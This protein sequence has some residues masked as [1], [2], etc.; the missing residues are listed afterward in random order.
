M[1]WAVEEWKD[2]LPGKALQKIQEMEVQL[3]K[4]KKERNQK[5]FQLDSLE[6]VLQKQKQKVDSERNEASVLKRENQSLVE[7]CDSIEKARQKVAHDL[8]IKEQQVSYLEGQLNSCRKTIERLEQELKKYKNELDRSQPA[9]SSSL[10]SSSELQPYTT[11]Q[12]TFPTP[13]SAYRQQDNR[14]EDLQD[15]YNQEVEER[16]RLDSELKILQVKLLNQSSASVSHKDIAARQAGSSVF[17]WQQQNRQS[18]DAT[19]TP[20]KRRATSLWDTHEET[21]IKPSQRMS[22]DR[23]APSPGGSQQMEQLKNLNQDLRGRVSELERSLSSHER[24]ISSQVSKLQDL[25]V[26]LTQTRKDLNERDRDLA[27]TSHD[28]RQ[29]TDRHQQLEVKCSSVEQKLKQVTEEMSCQ[30]HNAESCRQALEQKIK[31]QE[32]DGQ[33]ELSQLQR[34]HQV[35]EQQMEQTRTKLTQ[36]I[37]QSKKDNNIL[38]SDIDKICFQ[39]SHLEREVGEQKQKLLRS[40]QSLQT[41]QTK[42]EDLRKKLEEHQREKNSTSVQ[43]DQSNRRLSQLEEEKKT[44]DQT[45]KRNQGLLDDLKA[46]SENQQEELKR[47]Q[48]KLEQQTQASTRELA[49]LNKMVSD[50]ET[51]NE[52]FQKEM[53][54]QKQEADQSTNRLT[55]AVKESQELK[56][57]LA[58]SHDECKKLT[59]EHQALLDWKKEKEMLIN[60]VESMQ[61]QLTDKIDVLDN[62]LSSQKEANEE[63]KKQLRNAEE[64]Q[65]RLSAHIDSLKGE[66][67]IKITELEESEFQYKKLQ[68]QSSEAELK[69]NKDLANVGAQVAQLEI[70]VKDLQVRLQRETLRAEQAERS[71]TQLQ[72]EHQVAYNLALS[73]DQLLECSQAELH[74]LEERLARATA[75]H[76]D[77]SSRLSEE[78]A[79][80]LRQCEETLAVKAEEATQTKLRL[81]ETQQELLLAKSQISSKEQLLKVQ[82]QLG[83]ELQKQIKAMTA[84]EDEHKKADAEK[85]QKLQQLEEEL[86][87]VRTQM[88]EKEGQ[89]R[90]GEAQVLSLEK[91]NAI[92]ENAVKEM[93]KE[94]KLLMHAHDEKVNK[95]H[96]QMLSLEEDLSASKDAAE[97][98]PLLKSELDVANRL[99]ADLKKQ[100]DAIENSL[101]S[102]TEVKTNLEKTLTE[103]VSLC[104]ALQKEVAELRQKMSDFSESHALE[105]QSFLHNEKSLRE[106]LGAAE[107]ALSDIKEE[108]SHTRTEMKSM[109][110]TLSAASQGLE[111]RDLAIKSLKEQLNNAEAEQ[112][113]SSEQLKEK[114]VAMN[115]IKML[116]EMLQMDLEE[117]ET[118]VN[119]YQSQVQALKE[120]IQSLESELAHNQTRISS[121]EDWL[122][123]SKAQVSVLESRL[124]EVQSQNSVLETQY[125]TAREELLERSCEITRLEGD[126]INHSQLEEEV[127]A[128]EAKVVSLSETI[129]DKEDDVRQSH[130]EKNG[131]KATLRQLIEDKE[132]SQTNITELNVKSQQ[133][134][135][136]LNVLAEENK[137]LQTNMQLLAEEKQLS[138]AEKES[139]LRQLNEMKAQFE[140]NSQLETQFSVLA[141]ELNL[142]LEEKL[143]LEG[144][145][146]H[147]KEQNM[148]LQTCKAQLMEE[149]RRF[150]ESIAMHD[151]KVAS[152]QEEK[153]SIQNLLLSAQQECERMKG[154]LE[155]DT[156]ASNQ[157]FE[158]EQADLHQKLSCL[159]QELSVFRQ[160]YDSL[161]EQVGQQHHL[162]QQLSEVHDKPGEKFSSVEPEEGDFSKT[163]GDND[164]EPARDSLPVNEYKMEEPSS[165]PNKAASE[166]EAVLE[167][168]KADVIE[169]IVEEDGDASI[170]DGQKM[171]EDHHQQQFDQVGNAPEE[172]CPK[173]V[174]ENRAAAC[175]LSLCSTSE[176]TRELRPM[177]TEIVVQLQHNQDKEKLSAQEEKVQALHSEIE[178]LSSD[179]ALRKEL[180]SDLLAQVQTLENKVKSAEEETSCAAQKLNSALHERN[181][182][183]DQLSK[184]SEEKNTLALQ[185]QTAHCQLTDVM[186]MM[187]GLEM[188]KG[189]WDEKFLQQESELKRVRSEKANLEKHIL[190]MECELDA[191]QEKHSSLE[192]ELETQ[193][194]TC[195]GLEQQIETLSTETLQL[196]TELVSCIEER[197]EL[198]QSVGQWRQKVNRLEKTNCDTRS[199]M[200]ILDEDIKT[201]R[202]ENKAL[203]GNIDKIKTER[204]QLLDQL[205]VLEEAM[206]EQSGEK[207]QLMGQLD[208]IKEDRTFADQNTESMFS[209][210]QALEGEVSQL[211]QSLESSLLEKGEIA[212]RLNSTQDE[213]QQMRNGI[214]KLHVRIESDE[215]KKKQMSE[216]LKAAQRKADLLQD[217]IDAL[218]REKEELES[219]LEDAVLQAETSKEELEEERQKVEEERRDLNEELLKLSSTLDNLRSEKEQMERELQTKNL[220]LVEL[221][222]AKEELERGLER[223]EVDRREEEV[224]QRCR[225]EELEKG[226][227]EEMEKQTRQVDDLQ[228]QLEASRQREIS[229]KEKSAE[230]D[231]ERERIQCLLGEFEEEKRCLQSSLEKW[232][233]EGENWEGQKNKL[234]VRIDILEEDIV[235]TKAAEKEALEQVEGENRRLVEGRDRLQQENQ[236]L[237]SSKE[238]D[239]QNLEVEIKTLQ[240][241]LMLMVEEKECM[242]SALSTLEEEKQKAQCGEKKLSEEQKSLQSTVTTLE[243]QLEAKQLSVSKLTEQVSELSS[244]IARLAKQ[245]ESANT[246]LNL[247]MKT[248]KQLEQEKQLI[249]S[250]SDGQSSEE[251]KQ[252]QAEGKKEVEELTASLK[253]ARAEFEV[254]NKEVEE[255]KA[256]LEEVN[257][258]LKEVNQLVDEKTKEVDDTMNKYCSLMLEVHKLE[259]A[260][261]VL[262]TR[263]QHLTASKHA[264]KDKLHG[265]RRSARTSASVEEEN[266]ENTAPPTPQRSPQGSTSGKRAHRDM[267]DKDSAQ[268]ALHNLTKKIKA[269]AVTTPNRRSDQEEEFQPEG[270]PELVQKGFAD[271]PMGE[272]S[273]FIYRRTTV[274]RCSPRLAARQTTTTSDSKVLQPLFQQSPQSADALSRK[275]LSG[276]EKDMEEDKC[277]VQ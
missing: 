13:V 141:N 110:T 45:L 266:T 95:L 107:K 133:L 227:K 1:S 139:V 204:Q 145:N 179:L 189:G 49:N 254:K 146:N 140:I 230:T 164:L 63:M 91:Q 32:R 22:C 200:S 121:M 128:L 239:R 100:L 166:T 249:L 35:L 80:V 124:V 34:S 88:T 40:E 106:Q 162:I 174:F 234:M 136:R 5:Q 127:A 212:S 122:E 51:K 250:S 94:T 185:L 123:D 154:K 171:Q 160:K 228:V 74:Q 76:E 105:A 23:P 71:I 4:L 116:L 262:T 43:L 73:K 215:R 101:S 256:A 163:S 84:C 147:L 44:L 180:T 142:A 247:W 77:R 229:L 42:E 225:V 67:L 157:L 263:L 144:T 104:S 199:L 168:I 57:S 60:D 118:T 61:K 186:E 232:K 243:E 167:V 6:A 175:E 89:L 201:G 103:K 276:E 18:Q 48:S 68:T 15:K 92:L 277:H 11:P 8:G 275:C 194:R 208:K 169:D 20:L 115:K 131:L 273:P 188:A 261:E 165:Q 269:N 203:Q 86:K 182:L 153:E 195:S 125:F 265:R 12:K 252:L 98:L 172:N 65:A 78:K 93:A 244:R 55:Q 36:E 260:N 210:I 3:D 209:K 177:E 25:Q 96:E 214:E 138:I 258:E 226:M 109:K 237:N 235:K 245:R 270:L 248:C 181:G 85:L 59:Q 29:S 9:G 220:E 211:T 64:E 213:I 70:Q 50:T 28:L 178:L 198:S 222:A 205:K 233:T 238:E 268:E 143:Q 90:E 137:R 159:Q 52:R 24:E 56:N 240:S 7:S 152:L 242:T 87:D 108:T 120:T 202:K 274:R 223:A 31:D 206:S 53:Q 197:D 102:V 184:M 236:K 81:E 114:I 161:L 99:H 38:Q 30:R 158:T 219:N 41:S 193:K 54:K 46:K 72:E 183:S 82:Q 117:N 62:S 75:E 173:A 10:T 2:G 176:E 251:V 241:S 126:A 129:K 246:K 149:T 66:L 79:A 253:E 26:Q 207:D 192:D 271:I 267:R 272:A 224:R 19:E 135:T 113:K 170:E 47:L 14:L 97:K 39:K 221:K 191:L 27:K 111:E 156:G 119:S 58:A 187:E 255:L 218:E 21:P 132:Q 217:S 69:H 130:Q 190:G 150:Q 148:T 134:E 16:K 196:R 259:E 83:A 216:L 151:D 17:P 231:R 257:G 112:A 155:E 37:Q 264:N 33:K